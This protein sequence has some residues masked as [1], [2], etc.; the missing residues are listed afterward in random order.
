MAIFSEGKRP[1]SLGEVT[2]AVVE[3]DEQRVFS[4]DHGT[5]DV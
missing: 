1:P 5:H 4:S 2:V 3:S